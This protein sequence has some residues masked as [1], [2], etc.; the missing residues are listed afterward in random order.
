MITQRRFLAAGGIVLLF[1]LSHAASAAA[2]YPS[3][4]GWGQDGRVLQVAYDHGYRAGLQQG[5]NDAQQGRSFNYRD[6]RDYQR[7]DAGY[8]RRYGTREAYQNSYRQGYANGYTEAY[9]RRG[10]YGRAVPRGSQQDP[11]RYPGDPRYR[12]PEDDSRRGGRYG[13][14]Y[15]SQGFEIGYSEGYEKGLEDARDRDRYDPL[16]HKWYRE[17]DHGYNSRY[18]TR[19]QY[20]NA[21]RDGFRAGYD[22][23]YSEA[24][25]YSRN[26]NDRYGRRPGI[27]WPF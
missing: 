16:R 12:Y 4:D 17:G 23:G 19:E 11:R 18:G 20:K 27:F 15:G 25:R 26:R 14:G 9:N 21:Y 8:D 10:G 24:N 7:A 1:A 5:N 13:Y 22:R 3:R 6:N 2:Q